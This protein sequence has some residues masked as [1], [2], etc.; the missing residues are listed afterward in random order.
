M[1]TFV[2]PGYSAK[3]KEWA[4]EMAERLKLDGQI[5][6]IYWDHW[7]NP[8]KLFKPKEKARLIAGLAVKN[9]VNIIAKS[10]GTLVAA[11]V[12]GSIPEQIN[13]VIL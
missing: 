6:P 1:V 8:E 12:V 5:R 4:E 13:K 3:N 9:R 11:Y 10:V 7:E 2:L